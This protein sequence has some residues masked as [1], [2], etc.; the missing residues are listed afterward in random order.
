MRGQRLRSSI[1][2]IALAAAALVFLGG[3][4]LLIVGLLRAD[5]ALIGF[6]TTSVPASL[7][8]AAAVLGIETWAD[9]RAAAL[10]EKSRQALEQFIAISPAIIQGINLEGVDLPMRANM[11][12]W[13]SPALLRKIAERTR[14]I[15]VI[16][17]EFGP[18]VARV[19]ELAGDPNATV[20]IDIGDRKA[21]LAQLTVEA[22]AIA[23]AELGPVAVSPSEVYGVLY[24]KVNG[25]SWDQ[26]PP[27]GTTLPAPTVVIAPS[28]ESSNP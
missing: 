7:G 13:G 23:R 10:D 9:T 11:T 17:E 26:I 6:A 2:W 12:T 15:N 3:V 19:R 18:E 4:G 22:V 1:K 28:A 21:Q 16:A 27:I 24:G 5:A 20:T 8:A 14:L 25:R